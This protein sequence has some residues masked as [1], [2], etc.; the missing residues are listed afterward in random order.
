MRLIR[1]FLSAL[2]LALASLA[3]SGQSMP[4]P[5]PGPS[6]AEYVEVGDY[7]TRD[8]D[9]ETWY[10]ALHQLDADF[11][12]VCGD[13]FCEGDYSNIQSLRFLCSVEKHSGVIGQCVWVFAASNEEIGPSD[14][15]V[16]VDAHHW[17]CRIPLARPTRVAD[18][19][20]AL[21]GPQPIHAT[22]PGTATSI[23]DGLV[24]CL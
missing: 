13:T 22:L 24:D 10:T 7:L 12:D 19:L 5:V 11:D 15:R 16:M 8:A 18:L 6:S 3:A 9:I 21:A 20:A 14:G 1:S 2:P 17:R 23:Y 4:A